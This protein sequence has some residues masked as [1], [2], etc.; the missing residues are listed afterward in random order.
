MKQFARLLLI[1]L[2]LPAAAL[3]ENGPHWQVLREKSAIEWTATYGG[4][5]IKGT[6]PDFTADI[7]FDSDHPEQTK[8]TAKVAMAKVKSDD[9]DAQENLPSSDW[10]SV[11]DFPVAVFE[12]NNATHAAKDDYTATGTLTIRGK[13]VKVPLTFSVNFYSDNETSPS[14]RY[15]RVVAQAILKRLDFGVGQGDWAKT[16]AVADEVKVVVRLEAKQVP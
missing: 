2:V 10:L 7:T 16:D 15:A 8:V 1:A 11:S 13:T 4:K 5:P 12:M 9:K 6:F 3:A 14:T